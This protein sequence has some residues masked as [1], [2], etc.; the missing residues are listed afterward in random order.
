M[1]DHA[2]AYAARGWAVI[3]LERRGKTPLNPNGSKGASRS[4]L[5]ITE[6]WER[7]PGA[8]VGIATGKGSGLLVVDLDG[9]EG[10]LGWMA[11]V[12]THGA[13]WYTLSFRTGGGGAHLLYADTTGLPNSASRLADKVD[14]RGEGG[15]IV[16][17]PSIHPNGAP[18]RLMVDLPIIDVP[19]FVR[20]VL[21]PPTERPRIPASELLPRRGAVAPVRTERD[22][23]AEWEDRIRSAAEGQRNETLNRAAFLCG[24]DIAAGR[25]AESDVTS[26]LTRAARACGLT[27]RETERTLHSGL[28]AGMA[29]TSHAPTPAYWPRRGAHA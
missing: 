3:P 24:R 21:R 29:S 17:P 16:A 2:L 6:W 1:I 28:V 20:R 8:N 26:V 23:L 27:Q 19:A 25:M 22:F 18:Y 5:Q 14:T 13:P 11:L 7:W 4:P 9:A 10:V 12:A 15:Y